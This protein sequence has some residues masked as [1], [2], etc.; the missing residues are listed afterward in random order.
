MT[1]TAAG[2][3][4]QDLSPTAAQSSRL[5]AWTWLLVYPLFPA[6]SFCIAGCTAQPSSVAEIDV[7]RIGILPDDNRPNL[8]EN[9]RLLIRYLESELGLECRLIIPDSYAD[10]ER[11]FEDD[12]VDLA[13]LGGYT[14][15]RVS[16]SHRA[17]PLVSRD[18]D[19]QFTSYFLVRAE[20]PADDIRDFQS[21]RI[22]FGSELSTSGHLMP[23]HFL[24]SRSID[25]ET[26]FSE[27]RYMGAHH[28]TALAVRDA[29][30]DLGAASAVTV[31][32]MFGDGRLS[33][34]DVRILEQTPPYLNYV[35]TCQTRLPNS[36]RI[37]VRDAFL[38]LSSEDA[39]HAEILESLGA[40]Y[41]VPVHDEQ[42]S[43]LRE[44]IEQTVP[45]GTS[46]S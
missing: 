29:E 10:L 9:H 38:N 14:Y 20:S 2:S 25:P 44:T 35:W 37:R 39:I 27:I 18:R 36:L 42:F 41:F 4:R 7:L 40:R 15:V 1:S 31:D 19:L 33:P 5:I 12:D 26:F 13:W 6:I 23:R 21:K 16:Q 46:R 24:S 34:Q 32:A 22:A 45:E 3:C 30:V 8:E 43:G 11:A 17:V 28:Q